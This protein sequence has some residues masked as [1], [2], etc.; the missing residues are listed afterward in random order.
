MDAV[1]L[2]EQ[3]QAAENFG[4]GDLDWKIELDLNDEIGLLAESFDDMSVVNQD[5]ELARD[6]CARDEVIDDLHADVIDQL[7]Q[8]VIGQPE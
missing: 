8:L 2:A 3:A 5:V 6:V 1:E 4:R 7:Q